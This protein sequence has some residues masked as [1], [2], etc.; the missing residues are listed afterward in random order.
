MLELTLSFDALLEANRVSSEDTQAQL[1]EF[2]QMAWIK[3]DY[4]AATLDTG[5]D[6]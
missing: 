3:P 5:G 4:K 1:D 6:D 2:R